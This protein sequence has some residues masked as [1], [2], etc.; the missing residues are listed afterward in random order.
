MEKALLFMINS[1]VKSVNIGE[2]N[3]QYFNDMAVELN[4]SIQVSCT[5]YMARNEKRK[6]VYC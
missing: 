4:Y 1:I 3:S 6:V 2:I 5:L